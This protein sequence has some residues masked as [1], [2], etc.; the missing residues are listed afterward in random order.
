MMRGNIVTF[1]NQKMEFE[2]FCD[3][4]E[5]YDIELTRGDIVNILKDTEE[6]NPTLIPAILS[7][8]KN[9]YHLN[10]VY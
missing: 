10:L 1:G 4:I 8:I 6:K 3:R 2:Q 9:T 5:K 7:V